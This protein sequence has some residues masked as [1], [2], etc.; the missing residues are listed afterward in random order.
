MS[1]F[2]IVKKKRGFAGRLSSN[3]VLVNV[4]ALPSCDDAIDIQ[5]GDGG[6]KLTFQGGKWTTNESLGPVSIE[7]AAPLAA[8]A[9]RKDEAAMLEKRD[10]AIRKLRDRV[11]SLEDENEALRERERRLVEI[12]ALLRLD[13][14]KAG[15]STFSSNMAKESS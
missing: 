10:R 5:L 3:Q 12:V 4:D 8:A 1:S 15:L 9:P 13:L 14:H 11:S 6:P 2:E 7:N